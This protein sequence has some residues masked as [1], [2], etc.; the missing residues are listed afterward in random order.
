MTRYARQQ[1][2]IGAEAQARLAKVSVLVVGA[3]GLAAPVLQYLAGAGVGSLRVVDADVVSLSNLHRQ[4]L[5]RAAQVGMPKVIAAQDALSGLNPDV[6]IIAEQAALMPANADA[7]CD[8]ATV[9]LDCADSFA[10]SYILSDVC[11]D[12][13]IP[14]ISASVSGTN[15]YVGGF[16]GG[17]PSLRAVFPDLPERL[18]SCAVEGVLGPVVGVIGSLQAQM[19]LT[20]AAGD[21]APLGQITTYDAVGQR[22]GGF[23]FDT[24]PEP[25]RQ[26]VFID[27][28]A[29]RTDDWLVD[30]RGA[31][32]APLVH[33]EARRLTVDAFGPDGPVPEAGQRAVLCCKSGLRAWTAAQRLSLVWQGEIA[34]IALPDFP[35][36]S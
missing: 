20:V 29:L 24:A 8:G 10:V 35:N 7:L 15:G 27:P 1:A 31:E 5:F 32:E 33:P 9:V 12:R 4:T 17:K 14:L 22:F 30:L 25:D 3:G 26:A 2:V 23:R 28:D 36:N 13:G 21:P 19:A 34:L 11:T 6:R 18:G 16:C